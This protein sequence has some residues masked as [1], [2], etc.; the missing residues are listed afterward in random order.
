MEEKDDQMCITDAWVGE[1]EGVA[2][3]Q[4]CPPGYLIQQHHGRSEWQRGVAVIHRNSINI[5]MSSVLSCLVLEY[6]Y[7]MLDHWD[8]IGHFFH[9]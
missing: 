8:K 9:A 5:S 3:F 7:I 6:L 1:E 4:L 2:L